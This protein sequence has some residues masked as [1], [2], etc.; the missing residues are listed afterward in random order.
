MRGYKWPTIENYM[1]CI[2][3]IDLNLLHS[4]MGRHYYSISLRFR[5]G[6]MSR[7]KDK[8]RR[9]STVDLYKEA[10]VLSV[11]VLCS[12]VIFVASYYLY[13]TE[14]SMF[15]VIYS[16]LQKKTNLKIPI[17]TVRSSFAQRFHRF[18]FT[19]IYNTLA[20]INKIKAHL[21]EL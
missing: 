21:S 10:Q 12:Q 13:A 14:N 7:F 1:S 19:R 8:E 17:A 2:L 9:Y 11:R 16:D 4:G 20:N 5:K 18:Q 6:S 15:V 3:P